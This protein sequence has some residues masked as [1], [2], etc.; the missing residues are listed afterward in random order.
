MEIDDFIVKEF[1]TDSG[2]KYAVG[3]SKEEFSE[4]DL[5][6]EL[7]SAEPDEINVQATSSGWVAVNWPFPTTHLR[8]GY[9]V[10]EFIGFEH[11]LPEL[12]LR[13]IRLNRMD[14]PEE[15]IWKY[16]IQFVN[17]KGWGFEFKDESGDVYQITTI[18][19]G[20]HFLMFRSGYPTIVAVR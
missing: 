10:N 9:K 6:A 20:S 1:T 7:A 12:G 16:M 11:S 14:V 18:R 4:A 13:S 5:D 19:N 15:A 2:Q 17:D 3:Y 8:T